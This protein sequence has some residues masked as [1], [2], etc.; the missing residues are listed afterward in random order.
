MRRLYWTCAVMMVLALFTPVTYTGSEVQIQAKVQNALSVTYYQGLLITVRAVNTSRE[1]EVARAWFGPGGRQELEI[2]TP[3]WRSGEKYISDGVDTWLVYPDCRAVLLLPFKDQ[4]Q[5]L[6]F[7]K[8]A[9]LE[10]TERLEDREV[11]VFGRA[12]ARLR[13][14]IWIDAR[15]FVPLKREDRS[16]SGDLILSQTLSE[17]VFLPAA[18]TKRLRFT[19]DAD[20]TVYTEEDAFHRD[21]SLKHLRRAVDF[22]PRM[23]SFL[24]PG[25]AYLRA[26]L[27]VL[28]QLVVVQMRYSNS[29]GKAMSL[30]QYQASVFLES[31]EKR[32]MAETGAGKDRKFNFLRWR[33][34]EL[35]Y[36]LVANL[37]PKILREVADSL[38]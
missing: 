21:V 35:E 9:K 19:A 15:R 20:L 36:V 7:L 5:E 8:G 34:G 2:V 14:R 33:K 4:Y 23:P 18:P 13:R 1:D 27:V 6:A 11:Y 28:P 22:S 37:P 29:Q 30:F 38:K 10:G 16:V 24:P 3:S 25:F 12:N 26:L 32:L 17:V 31:P